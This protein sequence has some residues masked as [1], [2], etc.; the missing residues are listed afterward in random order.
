MTPYDQDRLTD[1]DR[2]LHLIRT[3]GERIAAG[4]DDLTVTIAAAA[5]SYHLEVV[6][7]LIEEGAD[8]A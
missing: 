5:M 3:F 8:E 1:I 7:E 2:R 4:L 6:A